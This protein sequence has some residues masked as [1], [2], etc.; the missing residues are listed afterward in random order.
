MATVS[1]LDSL[2]Q[3]ANSYGAQWV[4]GING[5]CPNILP[6]DH[7]RN[8]PNFHIST[9]TF[10][11]NATSQ[12]SYHNSWFTQYSS[13]AELWS[14]WNKPYIDAKF[15]RL[16]M[17]MEDFIYYP[18]LMLNI[19]SN[20]TGAPTRKPYS[21]LTGNGKQASET[22]LIHAMVKY[23]SERG[24]I[25]NTLSADEL[26]YLQTELDPEMMELFHYRA[27]GEDDIGRAGGG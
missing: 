4:R 26:R 19:I 12:H 1:S 27:I 25:P 3:C 14:Q 5:R 2:E 10:Q 24:R 16:I 13:L 7:D 18:E 22:S 9:T 6:N 23:G 21:Y 11:V 8:D 20:C 15:P 17:R